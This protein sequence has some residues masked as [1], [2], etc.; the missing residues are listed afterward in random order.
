MF[1]PEVYLGDTDV[2]YS[3]NGGHASAFII[4]VIKADMLS[5]KDEDFLI[6]LHTSRDLSVDWTNRSMKQFEK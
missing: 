1:G 6:T 2:N 5:L 4:K 3:Y